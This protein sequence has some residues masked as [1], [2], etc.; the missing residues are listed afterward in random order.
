MGENL[1]AACK[2]RQ[3]GFMCARLDIYGRVTTSTQIWYLEME[4]QGC[5]PM[6]ARK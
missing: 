4:I 5:D 1:A 6:G 2:L 3:L